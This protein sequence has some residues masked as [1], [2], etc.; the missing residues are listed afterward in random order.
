MKRGLVFGKFYPFHNGH[1]ALIRFAREQ[2]DELIVLACISDKELIP[3]QQ[4][5]AWIRKTFAADSG[6]VVKALPYREADLPNTSV[7]SEEVSKVWSEKFM[8][9]LPKIDMV[10]TGEDYGEYVARFMGCK[11]ARFIRPK[12]ISATMIRNDLQKHWSAMN[13]FAKD[14]LLTRVVIC[15]TESTGKST[16]AKFLAE[17]FGGGLV[18]EAGRDLISNTEECSYEDLRRVAEVHAE[19]IR[20][21]SKTARQVLFLDTDI[22]TTISYARFLFGRDM[23]PAPDVVKDSRGSLYLYLANDAPYVQDGTRLELERRDA[24]D[25][26]HRAVLDEEGIDYHVLRGS[27]EEKYAEAVRLVE[28]SLA[29]RYPWAGKT[30]LPP[31]PALEIVP[32][33]LVSRDRTAGSE[34]SPAP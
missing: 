5:L 26:S 29:I 9:V 34:I 3:E 15:G 25:A 28:Y 33:T 30:L 22:Y 18:T 16:L 17:R 11:H 1:E 4:R 14:D 27:W 19:R 8:Q 31:R 2:C 20:V 13:Q 7:S 10:C 24:L 6:I 23:E 21:A 12:E 32:E